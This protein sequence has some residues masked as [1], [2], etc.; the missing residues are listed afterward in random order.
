MGSSEPAQWVLRKIDFTYLGFTTHYSC[1][2]LRDKVRLVLLEL[3][4]REQ[5]LN[6]HEG[7]CTATQGGP[8]PFPTVVGT[9]YALQAVPAD[10]AGGSG[11]HTV[12][13]HWRTV[14]VRLG[15]STLGQAGQCELLEQVKERILPLF[16]A[17]NVRFRTDCVPHQLTLPGAALEVDVLKPDPPANRLAQAN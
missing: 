6:V 5:G 1:D 8:D 11:G 9:F 10:Q 2:G 13:A 12:A 16:D 17:R 7:G 4:A 15:D 14:R 3:G